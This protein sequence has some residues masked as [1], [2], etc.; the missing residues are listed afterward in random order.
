[1]RLRSRTAYCIF[2]YPVQRL[3]SQRKSLSRAP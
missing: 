2:H 3:I 1:L